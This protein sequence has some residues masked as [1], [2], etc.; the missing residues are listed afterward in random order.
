MYHVFYPN[1]LYMI[2]PGMQDKRTMWH[3][4]TLSVE[5]HFYLVIPAIVWFCVRRNMIRL[6]G[7]GMAA[8]AVAVGV[9]RLLA[10]TGPDMS[11]GMVSGVR[12]AFLQRPDALMVGVVLAVVNAHLD[13]DTV[14]R[15]R[16]MIV[17]LGT[18]GLVA[19]A[20][21]LNLS[22]GLVRKVGGPYFEYLP[23][24]PA[25]ADHAHM[26]QHWYWFR[27]GHTLGIAGVALMLLCMVRIR[28][29]WFARFLSAKPFLWMGRLS[30]TVYVWH[31]LP[32]VLL[33]AA[34]GGDG[35]S[36]T[37]KVL[38]TPLLIAAAIA[39]SMPVF[40]KVELPV[41]RMKLRFSSEAETVDLTTGKVVATPAGIDTSGDVADGPSGGG[42]GSS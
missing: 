1:G 34:T 26:V 37:V 8:G 14:Q 31:A 42:A 24:G 28:G 2:H 12:L 3:L 25:T 21:A 18:V 17:A 23:G 32:Y 6:L 39:V 7:V 16:G 35:A 41:M 15:Y 38:R 13:E 30:Y 20:A 29:W 36:P 4:W 22:S 40:Y 27:F 19:W 9:A 5:E 10:Y 11:P 33:L